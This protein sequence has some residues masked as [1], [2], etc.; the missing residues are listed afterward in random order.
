MTDI[1]LRLERGPDNQPV[2]VLRSGT[3]QLVE[4]TGWLDLVRV[5]ED[6]LLAADSAAD[7]GAPG[8]VSPSSVD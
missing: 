3:G 4:F 6:E 5:L 7:P 1:K 8:P 2:G